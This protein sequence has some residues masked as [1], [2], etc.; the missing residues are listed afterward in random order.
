[1]PRTTFCLGW[2]KPQRRVVW[3]SGRHRD[4]PVMLLDELAALDPA[5][6]REVAKELRTVAETLAGV[7]DSR[8][9]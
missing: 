6:R 4:I 3:P 1:M 5:Q 9:R 8:D 2:R 7:L